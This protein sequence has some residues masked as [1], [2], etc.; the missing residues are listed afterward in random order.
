VTPAR[1]R[2][3]DAPEK[4]H[5]I[6]ARSFPCTNANLNEFKYD[7]VDS[8]QHLY[9][10]YHVAATDMKALRKKQTT[11]QAVVFLGF[12]APGNKLSLGTPTQPVCG[13]I[14]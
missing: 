14:K 1:K 11:L 4:R 7:Y 13:S 12:P 10:Q 3:C 8:K 5:F 6:I 2:T 9:L